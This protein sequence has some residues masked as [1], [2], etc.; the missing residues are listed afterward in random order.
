MIIIACSS[1]IGN[2]FFQEWLS[3]PLIG[4]FW[5]KS[6]C[7]TPS[8]S[9]GRNPSF[10][11]LQ[12]QTDLWESVPMAEF[13]IHRQAN[14]IVFQK[15]SSMAH[16]YV[17]RQFS[18]N[19]ATINCCF[20]INNCC[21]LRKQRSLSFGLRNLTI[22]LITIFLCKCIVDDFITKFMLSILIV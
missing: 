11:K 10:T 20:W 4:H 17:W 7:Q 3:W 8:L 21:R 19:N 5:Q 9:T 2:I 18:V 12:F 13:L 15:G 1:I 6:G 16:W 22:W 14:L